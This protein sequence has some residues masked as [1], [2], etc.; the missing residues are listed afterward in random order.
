M[1][2]I[3]FQE[4]ARQ[5]QKS[6]RCPGCGKK[7]RR[8]RTFSMTLNPWNKDPETGLPRA[9]RQIWDALGADVAEWQAKP[10]K[11]T[12]CLNAEAAI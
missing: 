6:L 8:Q 5:G 1:T 11:C 9:R 2:T 12:P 10:E 3:R 7:V 4:F